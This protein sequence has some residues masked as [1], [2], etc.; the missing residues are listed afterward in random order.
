MTVPYACRASAALAPSPFPAA[1][2]QTAVFFAPAKVLE[3]GTTSA[4]IAG[5]GTVTAES[6]RHGER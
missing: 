5:T 3:Q 1:Q 6:F 4:A 2:A